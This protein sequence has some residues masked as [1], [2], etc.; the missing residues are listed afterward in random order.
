MNQGE[1]TR[2]RP[3]FVGNEGMLRLRR[4]PSCFLSRAMQL[5]ERETHA[6]TLTHS[7]LVYRNK[8]KEEIFDIG[9]YL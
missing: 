3:F 1:W 5:I 9:E 6:H 8:I 7:H 4:G 2:G